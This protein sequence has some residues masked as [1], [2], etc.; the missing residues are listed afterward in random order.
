MS[1]PQLQ[2]GS[3]S[4]EAKKLVAPTLSQHFSFNPGNQALAIPYFKGGLSLQQMVEADVKMPMGSIAELAR[5]QQEQPKKSITQ[6]ATPKSEYYVPTTMK[7]R[8]QLTQARS[9]HARQQDSASPLRVG[10]W[11]EE[12]RG[13]TYQQRPT[14]IN[15]SLINRRTATPERPNLEL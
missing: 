11:Q 8:N 6:A 15:A 9:L 5:Q 7:F 3:F 10:P 14:S 2:E 12:D 13:L 1:T 4:K